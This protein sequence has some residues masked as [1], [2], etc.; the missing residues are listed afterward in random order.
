M[1]TLEAPGEEVQNQGLKDKL[2]KR[3]QSLFEESISD[4]SFIRKRFPGSHP[5]SLS[6]ESLEGNTEYLVC[7]KS[8][9]VRYL[10]Y[11]AQI[12]KIRGINEC[13]GFLID[14]KYNF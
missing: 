5:I 1:V 3:I 6:K 4:N 2:Y 13:Q 9:G 7:E 8:D 10:L 11:I 12:I 14:R